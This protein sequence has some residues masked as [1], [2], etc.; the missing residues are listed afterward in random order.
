MTFLTGNVYII[1]NSI[2][3]RYVNNPFP[4]FFTFMVISCLRPV[5]QDEIPFLGPTHL[6]IP[7]IYAHKFDIQDAPVLLSLVYGS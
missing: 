1:N 6:T 4:G 5:G 2:L 7:I 3:T